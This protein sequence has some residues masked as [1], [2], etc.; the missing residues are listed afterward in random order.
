MAV[1]WILLATLVLAPI[2]RAGR[3]S[4]HTMEVLWNRCARLVARR[5]ETESSSFG[6]DLVFSVMY[7]PAS[8]SN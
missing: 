7:D 6:T 3:G 1:V 8:H 5:R 2:A 4:R